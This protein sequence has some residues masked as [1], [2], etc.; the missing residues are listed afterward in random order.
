MWATATVVFLF[1]FTSFGVV[2]LL[3]GAANPTIE[4]E[5][6]RRATQLGDVDG[7]AVLSVL[8]LTVL[9]VV[10]WWSARWQ[11]RA[12]VKLP[13]AGP[14]RSVRTNGERRLVAVVAAATTLAMA[15][16]VVVLAARSVRLGG[17]WSLTAWRTLG[18][19]E[20]RPGIS[21]GVD[22]LASLGTSLRFAALATVVSLVSG[23]L[24]AHSIA[25]ARRHGKLLDVGMML[26]LG[27]SAVTS[28]GMGTAEM[29]QIAGWIDQ[30]A[31]APT[32]A[33]VLARVR[34]EVVEVTRRFPA[35]GLAI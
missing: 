11:R 22:P 2:K 29:A 12:A 25:A 3:G 34:G 31:Q 4:V 28:R 35:P 17:R 1:T 24:A 9:A 33:A 20:I 10:V 16:P 30:V 13:G 5:I 21:L 27:T 32:D 14:A 18:S 15:A 23:G 8:Q 6:A 26:P 7:A 19:A